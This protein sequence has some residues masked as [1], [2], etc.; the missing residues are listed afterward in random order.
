MN[1]NI[2]IIIGL[3]KNAMRFALVVVLV[4]YMGTYSVS[5]QAKHD[6]LNQ[7]EALKWKDLDSAIAILRHKYYQT[8]KE[9]DSQCTFHGLFV[10]SGLSVMMK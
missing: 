8:R 10:E 2:K 9:K 3:V 6:F 5:A 4:S 7:I 1:H